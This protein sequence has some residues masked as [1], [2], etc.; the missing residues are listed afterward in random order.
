MGHF[1]TQKLIYMLQFALLFL[2]VSM[3]GA[4]AADVFC[5]IHVESYHNILPVIENYS[6]FK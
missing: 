2:L 4:A 1:G 3:T 6:Y 5:S